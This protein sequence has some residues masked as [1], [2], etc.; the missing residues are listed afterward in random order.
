MAICAVMYSMVLMIPLAA[1]SL[2]GSSIRPWPQGEPIRIY[3][4]TVWKNTV[5]IAARGFNRTGITPAIRFVENPHN[6]DV[7]ISAS[8]EAVDAQ[9]TRGDHCLGYASQIGYHAD[10]VATIYLPSGSQDLDKG[11]IRRYI[12][13]T[14]HEFGHILGLRH[15]TDGCSI[16][17]SD[18]GERRC[19][20]KRLGIWTERFACGP[21]APD[22]QALARLY[23][24]PIEQSKDITCWEPPQKPPGKARHQSP[25]AGSASIDYAR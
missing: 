21:L 12:Q 18:M 19:G 5:A 24:R 2:A 14:V 22:T 23:Q 15:I 16:L 4:P 10:R 11:I 6:A 9:C 13:L 25:S 20:K 17:N 8:D 3:N 1:G 7:I